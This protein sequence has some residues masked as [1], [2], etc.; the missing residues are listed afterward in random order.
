MTTTVVVVEEDVVVELARR[1]V[2]GPAGRVV[3]GA[4]RG[5]VVV[6]A[7]GAVVGWDVCVV[8]VVVGRTWARAPG[9]DSPAAANATTAATRRPA[10]Q[11]L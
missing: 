8:G 2:G 3:D 6:G 5:A 11:A 10:R 7:A 4:A 1:V 9:P